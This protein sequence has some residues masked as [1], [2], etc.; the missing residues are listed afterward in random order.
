MMS[1]EAKNSIE[2][3]EL[4]EDRMIA[5]LS[6]QPSSGAD[7]LLP[8]SVKGAPEELKPAIRKKQNKEVKLSNPKMVQN[9]KTFLSQHE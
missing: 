7:A 9:S 4:D 3:S 6:E 8:S 5:T 1:N 2:H